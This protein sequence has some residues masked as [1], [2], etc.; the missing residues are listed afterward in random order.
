MMLAF[1]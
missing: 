1:R